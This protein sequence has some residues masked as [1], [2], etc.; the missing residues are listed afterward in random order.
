MKTHTV[1]LAAGEGKRMLSTKAKSLQKLG[2]HS[3]LKRIYD[4]A[5]DLTDEFTA[6]VGHGKESVIA[7]CF[8]LDKKIIVCE[9]QKALGTAD[10]VKS[11][12]DSISDDSKVLVLYGDVPLIKPRTVKEVLL[13]TDDNLTILTTI[14]QNP[15]GYG[16]VKKSDT[17][18]VEAIVEEKDA[19]SDEKN[20]NEIFTGVLCCS[21]PL[22]EDSINRINNNNAAKEYYLTD[23]ISIIS[24]NGYKINTCL[25]SNEEVMGAN[26]KTE[27]AVLEKMYRKM[28]AKELLELGVT[29]SD[30]DRVDIRGNVTV[31]NDC[32]IDINVILDGNIKLGNNVSIGANTILKNVEL[33]DNTVIE[34]FSHIVSSQVGNNC[35]IGPYARLREGSHLE[36]NVRIGNFVE[37]KKTTIGSSTK[38]NHF[39]YL[40]D[41][42]IGSD[43]NI[44][45]G[46]ITCNYDGKNKNKTIIGNKSFVGTNSSLV[47][48]VTIGSNAYIAAGSVITKD[49]P[50]SALGVGRSKQFNKE[51]WSKS[52]D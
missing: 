44:G 36:D 16:R 50:D 9:Q 28:K 34:P 14:L 6:V 23:I 22:L 4:L 5:K 49:V 41:A 30:P 33:G 7:E 38:A 25:A 29:I 43:S 31:G 24:K 37:T 10:A 27:L 48:P 8:K 11:A 45:A 40:G 3:M 51:N 35:S 19:T 13:K 46:S 17:G 2:G 52:K 32:S 18:V 12:L 42:E 47:A 15:T 26:S 1:I 20:I 21:K 39:S